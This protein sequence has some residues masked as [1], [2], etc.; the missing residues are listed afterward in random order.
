MPVVCDDTKIGF[1]ARAVHF[2][3]DATLAPVTLVREGR[4]FVPDLSLGAYGR[5]RERATSIPSR[6]AVLGSNNGPTWSQDVWD[7]STN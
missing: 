2:R 6:R 3:G 5:D 7:L 1:Y 4:K